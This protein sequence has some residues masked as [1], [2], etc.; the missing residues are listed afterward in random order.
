ME[1][2]T[3]LIKRYDRL[4]MNTDNW[5][6]DWQDINDYIVLRNGNILGKVTPG[7]K[8][9]D[10]IYDSTAKDCNNNLSAVLKSTL[11][12][13]AFKWFS[14]KIRG[15][16]EDDEFKDAQD[17]LEWCSLKMYLALSQSNFYKAIQ[18]SWMQLPAYGT[19][20]FLT[21]ER[22]MKK[23]GFNGFLFTNMDIGSYCSEEGNEGRVNTVFRKF[24][25]SAGN[26][27]AKWGTRA[28]VKAV[29]AVNSDKHEEMLEYV[30]CILPKDKAQGLD[31][32]PW[33]FVSY[34][35]ALGDKSLCAE[36]GYHEFPVCVT[37]WSGSEPY[38]RGCGH[39]CLPDVKTLNKAKE[40]ELKMWA[41]VLD[42]PLQVPHNGVIGNVRLGAGGLTYVMPNR[43]IKPIE[44][45]ARFDVSQIKQE[46]LKAS[47]KKTW[48]VDQLQ[49]PPLDKSQLMTASEA[50]IRR[51]QMER[52]L[53]ATI[54][55]RIEDE[56]LNPM[57]ER[58]FALMLRAGALPPPPPQVI[59]LAKRM[60]GEIDIEYESPLARSQRMGD[61]D[62]INRWL[63]TVAPIIDRYPDGAD[64]ADWDKMIRHSATVSGVPSFLL[65][66]LSLVK[67]MR[68]ARQQAQAEELQK[69]DEM[70]GAEM[71]GKLAPAAKMM[72]EAQGGAT[73]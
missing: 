22:T 60:G 8:L 37:R 53:G 52:V 12:N 20:A 72:Q 2:V 54:L 21:E 51:D 7:M 5:R 17:W 4:M 49:F 62:A 6:P 50:I 35:I 45:G 48:Y 64:N 65:N 25:M 29:K 16:D 28:G 3:R 59:E 73:A 34:Y 39:D 47:I 56:K 66:D 46:E 63:A 18:E 67:E 58:Q 55:G 13:P 41:K 57:I 10:K 42:P 9:T 27:V 1:L 43:E 26:A 24:E 15:L 31:N 44:S 19:D 40:L 23:P 11:T 36:G 69:Q 38:G 32:G 68:T 61:I 70:A 30:H 71:V 33:P 14:L